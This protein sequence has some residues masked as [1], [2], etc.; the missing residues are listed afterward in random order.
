MISYNDILDI[1]KEMKIP[2]AYHHFIIDENTPS[3]SP[4][5]ILYVSDDSDGFYADDRNYLNFNNF[6][7]DLVTE[8][9]DIELESKLETLFFN[10]G[11]PFEKESDNYIE[12]EEIYQ[13][14]YLI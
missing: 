3:P 14:R 5:F 9:K 7:I 12:N 4:P 2:Y 1:L 10:A 11:I 8:K 6:I 13:I